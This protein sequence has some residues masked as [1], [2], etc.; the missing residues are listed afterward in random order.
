[1]APQFI[2][3]LDNE[4]LFYDIAVYIVHPNNPVKNLTGEQIKQIQLGKIR[5]W[6]DVGGPDMPLTLIQ[7]G[8]NNVYQIFRTKFKIRHPAEN[9]KEAL[10]ERADTIVLNDSEQ[11]ISAIA[12]AEGAIGY[13]PF[14][15]LEKAKKLTTVV[16]VNGFAPTIKDVKS[17]SYPVAYPH[18]W[19]WRTKNI[20]EKGQRF[21]DFCTNDENA[22]KARMEIYGN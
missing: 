20:N 6:K 5:N 19:T 18:V 21:K 16:K 10:P 2:K 9:P 13:V 11:M 14:R 3:G 22:I 15:D 17:G 12:N 1:M 8:D 7:H 4:L